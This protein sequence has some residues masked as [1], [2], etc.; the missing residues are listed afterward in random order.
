MIRYSG[1]PKIETDRLI[2]RR[3]ER[4]DAQSIYDHWR[5]DERVSENRINPAHKTIS[6][7]IKW[8]NNILSQ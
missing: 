2:L 4:T 8:L 3:M 5:S 7:T 6:E 1:T